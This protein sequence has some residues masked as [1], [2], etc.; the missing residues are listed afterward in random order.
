[1]DKNVSVIVFEKEY[2]LN[3]S[4]KY[5]YKFNNDTP[6]IETITP[7]VLSVLGKYPD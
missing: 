5:Q 6:V 7:D 2:R 1:M 4:E 3:I